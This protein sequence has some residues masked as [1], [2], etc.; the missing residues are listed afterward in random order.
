M[1]RGILLTQATLVASCAIALF[2]LRGSESGWAALF[3][4]LIALVNVHM[5]CWRRRQARAA[6]GLDARASLRALYRSALERFFLVA[7]LFAVALGMLNLEPLGL[8][9]GFLSGQAAL[10]FMWSE[11]GLHKRA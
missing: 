7:A 10:L 11:Q 5:L 3:G 8:F 1:G 2:A 6:R 9:G 4:G